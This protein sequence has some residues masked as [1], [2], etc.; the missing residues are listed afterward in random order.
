[1]E[2]LIEKTLASS[3]KVKA[4]SEEKG[5][6]NEIKELLTSMRAGKILPLSQLLILILFAVVDLKDIILT[7]PSYCHK[8]KSIDCMLW[9]LCYYKQIE[10]YRLGIKQIVSAIEDTSLSTV[11]DS[12]I[13]AKI[14]KAKRKLFKLRKGL[15]VF[16]IE[17]I[18]FYQE[19]MV[20]LEQKHNLGEK[21][22]VSNIYDCLLYLGDLSRY[23][24][25]YSDD[26][27]HSYNEAVRYYVRASLLVPTS[28]NSHNQLAVLATY[29]EQ[30]CVAVYHYCRSVLVKEPMYIGYTN[31]NIIFEKQSKLFE[32]LKANNLLNSTVMIGKSSKKNEAMLRKQKQFFVCFTKLHAII[33]KW[34]K[35]ANDIV[36]CRNSASSSATSDASMAD[37]HIDIDQFSALMNYVLDEF[38]QLIVLAVSAS[39]QPTS[40]LLTSYISRNSVN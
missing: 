29:T 32:D 30:D 26:G 33:F 21:S 34:S 13:Q 22:Y 35:S 25:L 38:D 36:V 3:A 11:E 10:Q 39:L 5:N 23:Q 7:D 17:A 12:V 20:L 28:G 18:L 40:L 27:E 24:Q 8:G 4:L 9:K 31:L 16:L 14:D 6:S 15:K 19:F 1:M 2:S 37:I